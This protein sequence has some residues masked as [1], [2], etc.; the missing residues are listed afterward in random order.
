MEENALRHSGTNQPDVFT[1][2]QETGLARFAGPRP[3]PYPARHP[4]LQTDPQGPSP[5]LGGRGP[6]LGNAGRETRTRARDHA[7][8]HPPRG[9]RPADTRPP[10]RRPARRQ[11]NRRPGPTNAGGEERSAWPAG[12]ASRSGGAGQA[13]S[14]GDEAAAPKPALEAGPGQLPGG[15][16]P[17]FAKEDIHILVSFKTAFSEYSQ[18]HRKSPGFGMTSWKLSSDNT[19]S[20]PMSETLLF[21]SAGNGFTVGDLYFAVLL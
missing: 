10:N 1:V 3:P 16:S 9:S 6:R 21:V 19:D 15:A 8:R 18:E 7:R 14:R 5:H 11:P 12:H 20:N 4:R 17:L 13:A 2:H